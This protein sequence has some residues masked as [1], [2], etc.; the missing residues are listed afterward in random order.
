[1]LRLGDLRLRVDG[2][3]YTLSNGFNMLMYFEVQGG[4]SFWGAWWARY[5]PDKFYF[6]TKERRDNFMRAL[7]DLFNYHR[8]QYNELEQMVVQMWAAKRAVSLMH[9]LRQ[10]DARDY[11]VT[12]IKELEKVYRQHVCAI[13]SSTNIEQLEFGTDAFTFTEWE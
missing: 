9:V 11:C 12:R 8:Q 3:W 13:C 7:S 2:K 10:K 1:M 5:G 6:P 4:R